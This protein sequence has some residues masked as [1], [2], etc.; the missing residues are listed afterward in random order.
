MA[1]RQAEDARKRKEEEDAQAKRDENRRRKAEL[2]K[3]QGQDK[4]CFL[5]KRVP[6]PGTVSAEP[7]QNFFATSTDLTGEIARGD[8]LSLHDMTYKVSTDE[9][10]KFAPNQLPVDPPFAGNGEEG[11][12]GV[13]SS[14][15]GNSGGDGHSV[16]PANVMGVIN[17]KAYK[18]MKIP[19][20]AIMLKA[21][22]SVTHGSRALRLTNDVRFDVRPGDT[23]RIGGPVT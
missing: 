2:R 19:A 15:C 1:K 21:M 6:L 20:T 12:L 9:G 3:K 5:A 13:P 14:M 16:T 7:G 22:V 18:I 23:L 10:R 11:T 8:E 4:I 17:A